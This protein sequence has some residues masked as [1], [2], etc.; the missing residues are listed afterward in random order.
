MRKLK[1]FLLALLSLLIGGIIL[2]FALNF[3]IS[4]STSKNIYKNIED[5]P[6][7]QTVIIL[8]A[9][10]HS[11]G[12]LSP[13]LQDRMDTGLEL[14]RNGKVKNFLLTGDHR[15][16][17]YNEVRAMKNYL[18]KLNVPH[19][20]IFTDPGGL[21]TYE[22]M[23]RSQAVFDVSSAVV[24]TQP[25]HLPRT[26]FIA[27]GLG[28]DYKGYPATSHLYKT[29]LSL[30]LREKLANIKAFI[31]IFGPGPSTNEFLKQPITGTP[32]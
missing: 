13:V 29:E 22:S 28:L 1:K 8:G 31:A 2:V 30:L 21:N 18:L 11:D 24:V 32:L 3:Y 23:F 5:L 7:A 15:T 4:H 10:V 16:D 25:F 19:D 12:R 20:H 26:L 27:E 17:D 9:S 6:V 14:Y